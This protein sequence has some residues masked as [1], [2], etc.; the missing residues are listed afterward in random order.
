MKTMA[1]APMF[2]AEGEA[3]L[4]PVGGA[5]IAVGVSFTFWGTLLLLVL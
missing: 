2:E 4:P 5:V 3:Q 1:Q